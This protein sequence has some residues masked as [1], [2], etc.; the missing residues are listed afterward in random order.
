MRSA[1]AFVLIASLVL[2][3]ASSVAG[4]GTA[5][6]RCTTLE[7]C[8]ELVEELEE[9]V[10]SLGGTP[11][12]YPS[13]TPTSD[14]EVNNNRWSFV[15]EYNTR[16][17]KDLEFACTTSDMSYI[18]SANSVGDFSEPPSFIPEDYLDE[19]PFYITRAE[20]QERLD[21]E[22]AAAEAAGEE[23]PDFVPVEAPGFWDVLKML[24]E[25]YPGCSKGVPTKAE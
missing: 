25:E 12:S 23:I 3:G 16:L 4:Q 11:I 21:T 14:P 17:M 1:W 19:M 24:D 9:Q 18:F 10:A 13:P 15:A 20:Y 2:A 6:P 22:R 5:T 8:Q 7:E